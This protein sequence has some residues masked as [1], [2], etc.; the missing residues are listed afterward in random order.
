VREVVAE[1]RTFRGPL[2][3]FW[4]DQLFMSRAYARALLRELEPVGKRWAA[5]VTLASTRDD[6]LL[7]AAARAGCTCL[8][9]G[10]E[11]FSRESLAHANKAFNLIDAYAE[12]VARIHRH[13]IAV[14]AGIIFG[15]DGDDAST[16]DTTL[17]HATRIGLDGATISI[18]TPFPR[19]AVFETLERA[20]RLLTR[21]WSY[22]N[23]KTAVTFRPARMSADALFDG[24]TRF[25]RELYSL[26][27]IFARLRRS[28]IRPAQGLVLNL[29]YRRALGAPIPG[30]PVPAHAERAAPAVTH[31]LPLVAAE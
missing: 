14:Q 7:A 4:D 9:L 1:I 19:T 2:F 29:G 22:F 6:A 3:T 12:G 15:F 30:R 26:R 8:F 18:L 16:F 13:G 5:M 24:Y 21:D 10:L 17:E 23:G 20:G 28:S 31:H 27:N 25:R 11:S